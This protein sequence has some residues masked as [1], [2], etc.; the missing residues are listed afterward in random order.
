MEIGTMNKTEATIFRALTMSAA[1][2][3]AATS[4]AAADQGHGFAFGEPGKASQ[5]SRTMTITMRDVSYEPKTIMVR[6]GETIRFIVKNTGGLLHEFN[7]GTPEMH[8]EHRKEMAEMLKSGMITATGI[9]HAMM[10]MDHSGM[11]HSKMGMKMPMRHD[12]PNSVLVEPG[13]TTELVWKFTKVATLQFSCN[14][15]DHSEAGMVGQVR[16]T[17]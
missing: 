12:D 13:K 7:L 16:F 6:S 1:F 8:V 5:V 2:V 4:L 9:N 3:L 17:R 14:V 11:D 10:N 15:P